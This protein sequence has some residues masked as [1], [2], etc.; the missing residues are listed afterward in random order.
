MVVAV[1]RSWCTFIWGPGV[2]GRSQLKIGLLARPTSDEPQPTTA[3]L[4]NAQLVRKLPARGTHGT[5]GASWA[6][7]AVCVG[8]LIDEASAGFR[9]AVNDKR[10]VRLLHSW[11][12]LCAVDHAAHLRLADGLQ[13]VALAF[14]H[15][16]DRRREPRPL[17]VDQFS[18]EYEPRQGRG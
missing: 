6:N 14:E 10:W 4:F 18:S 8:R 15:A 7:A 11:R 5:D 17:Q 3:L 2:A 13:E 12:M 9:V 1:A 16:G